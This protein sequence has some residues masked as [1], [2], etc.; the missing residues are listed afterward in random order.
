[1]WSR[2]ARAKRLDRIRRRRDDCCWVLSCPL[3]SFHACSYG[4]GPRGR[5]PVA[6]NPAKALIPR[7]MAARDAPEVRA[8]SMSERHSGKERGR[9]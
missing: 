1:M 6:R 8:E 7:A 2:A 4:G 3:C 9:H 5:S